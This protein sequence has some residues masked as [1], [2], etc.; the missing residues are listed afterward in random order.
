MSFAMT[1]DQFKA[2]TKTVTRRFGWWFLKPGDMVCGVEK[3]MGLKKGEKINRLGVIEIV[4]I[5]TEPLNAIT[6]EDVVREGFPDWTPD[7]F[8]KMLVDHYRVD[9]TKSVNRIEYRYK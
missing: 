8:V 6:Q 2:R 9:P 1:T 4:S 3:G 5:R 7:Q